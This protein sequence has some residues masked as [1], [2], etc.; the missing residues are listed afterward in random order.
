MTMTTSSRLTDALPLWLGSIRFRLTA[1][2]SIVLFGLAAFVVGL[3]YLGLSRS[4]DDEPVSRRESSAAIF[5]TP[6]GQLFSGTLE[7]DVP[8]ELA[9]FEKQVNTRALEQLKTYTFGALGLLFVGSLGVGWWV[10]GMVLRPVGRITDVAREIQATDMSR[11][12]G[13]SGPNDEM[14]QLADTFDDMLERLQMAFESQQ[15]FIQE[16][17]HELRNPLATIRTNLDV[18]LA[19]PNT[20]QSELRE[21][22]TV[23]S[24]SA[25]RMSTL[26]DDLLL[27]ARHELPDD[28]SEVIDLAQVVAGTVDEFTLPAGERSIA[29]TSHAESVLVCGDRSALRRA[30]ANLVA[31]AVRL[32]P[33][34]STVRV[35]SRAAD[36]WALLS[37]ADEGP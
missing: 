3:I 19:D 8:D 24:R 14:R 16:A 15:L 5:Q 28:R 31:N 27:H 35:E 22:S 10:A 26:V 9:V 11:R 37:V 4:L 12:I 25:E 2:Y 36:D 21:V 1:V 7:R 23:V 33:E 13:L 32:A 20:S 30:L 17:S 18:A 34:H 29:I 6:D